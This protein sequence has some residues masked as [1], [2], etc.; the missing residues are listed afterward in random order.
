MNYK[1]IYDA[2]VDKAK[3]RGLD[4]SQH[5][6]YFEIHHI[7]PRSIGGSNEAD[8][9]VMFTAREHFIAHI[10]LWKIYP[11]DSNLFHAAWMMS[12]RTLTNRNSKVYA[13]LREQHATILSTRC[14]FNNPSFKDLVGL[15]KGRLKVLEFAGWTNQAKGKRTSTWL[16]ECSCGEIV[17]L[18]AKE[19]TPKSQYMSCGC[20]KLDMMKEAVGEKNHFFGKKHSDES[21]EKMRLKKLGKSPINKGVP[22]SEETRQKVIQSLSEL[23]RVPWVKDVERWLLA[24]YYFSLWETNKEI[25]AAQFST[26][27]NKLHND[28]VN[29]Y[30]FNTMVKKFKSGWNPE[31]D[32]DWRKLKQD[33]EEERDNRT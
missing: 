24:D 31:K 8:N 7:V 26:L 21:K 18:G 29:P 9:L 4:K 12:N 28:T 1:K 6:G 11:E 33:H 3:P 25:T 32:L 16:C 19:L 23:K 14:E 30:Y 5:E 10:L 20:Y 15:Q 2:L 17:T 27:Y 13:K 22:M